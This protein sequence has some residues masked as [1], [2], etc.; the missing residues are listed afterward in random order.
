[1]RGFCKHPVS[2]RRYAQ[3]SRCDHQRWWSLETTSHHRMWHPRHSFL[4]RR[5][6]SHTCVFQ[7]VGPFPT[8]S[9]VTV[10]QVLPEV[11]R[12]E[13]LLGL[14]TFA[15]FV[16]LIK[17]LRTDIPLRR[18]GEFVATEATNIGPVR[19]QRGVEGC[20]HPSKRCT[21]PGVP[22]QMQRVLVAFCFV[23]VLEAIRTISTRVLL[24]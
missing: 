7:H 8:G 23:L 2:C 10:F 1:M 21:R 20:L 19:I 6:V 3:A 5:L 24:L 12:S 22:S 13:E 16:F 4:W 18:V 9:G 17:M 15:E 14:V 11:I